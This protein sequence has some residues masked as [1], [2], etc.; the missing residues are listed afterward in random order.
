MLM[1]VASIILAS[2]V[3]VDE[4]KMLMVVWFRILQVILLIPTSFMSSWW[5]YIMDCGWPENLTSKILGFILTST[6]L[7]CLSQI[8]LMFYITIL[9][10]FTILKN[11]SLRNDNFN[12]FILLKRRMIML[13]I[14]QN[15]GL[16]IMQCTWPDLC[17]TSY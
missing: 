1:A 7:L 5:R 14:E 6:L 2:H 17:G 11:F 13:I 15:M 16:I 8:L 9:R 12:Y 3:F 4:F 10:F